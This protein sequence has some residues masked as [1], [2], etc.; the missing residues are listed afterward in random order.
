MIMIMMIAMPT[1]MMIIMKSIRICVLMMITMILVITLDNGMS[2]TCNR[3][4]VMTSVI[5]ILRLWAPNA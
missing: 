1:I 5:V 2:T 4:I 3:V